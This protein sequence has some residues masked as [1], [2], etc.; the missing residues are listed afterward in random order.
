MRILIA[1]VGAL[2]LTGCHTANVSQFE[3]MDRSERTITVPA[4]SSLLLGPIKQA[5]SQTGWKMSV[6]RGPDVTKGTF[7]ERTNLANSNT[8]LSRYRLVGSQ[9]QIDL[10]AIPLGN[11]LVVYD[12]SVIDNKTGGEV[13]TQNGRG[14]ID[15][16]AKEFVETLNGK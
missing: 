5:L 13:M 1:T 8:F 14:C 12:L 9:R 7:G 2:A 11:P 16:V 4:G 3:A 10:C 15:T 6:D